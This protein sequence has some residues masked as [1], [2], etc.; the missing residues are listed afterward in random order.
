MFSGAA[1]TNGHRHTEVDCNPNQKLKLLPLNQHLE[2]RHRSLKQR[3]LIKSPVLRA[4]RS[5][6]KSPPPPAV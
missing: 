1:L 2:S 3:K 5:K 4:D 6:F